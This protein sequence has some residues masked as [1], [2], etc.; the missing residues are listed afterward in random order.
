MEFLFLI[1]SVNSNSKIK[2]NGN[3][4]CLISSI[5]LKM[6]KSEKIAHFHEI[7]LPKVLQAAVFENAGICEYCSMLKAKKA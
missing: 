6:K 3:E 1:C 2:A 5:W 4:V 7:F